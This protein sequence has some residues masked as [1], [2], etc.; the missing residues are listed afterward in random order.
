MSYSGMTK[1]FLGLLD[2]YK[3]DK[4][5]K[6][7]KEIGDTVDKHI[8][9]VDGQY[10]FN[11]Q[12]II[13]QN[14]FLL[15]LDKWE[16]F[17]TEKDFTDKKLKD[18][19]NK[20]IK[21]FLGTGES[22][23][24]VIKRL[25]SL[26]VS[27]GIESFSQ[28]EITFKFIKKWIK[29]S[30]E[31]EVKYRPDIWLDW[32][33]INAKNIS[34]STHVAKL[35]HSSIKGATNIYF[36]KI[37]KKALFF[38]TSSLFEKATD[39]SQTD[40]KLSPIGKFL[41]LKHNNMRM[42]DKLKKE[43]MS[44][45]KSFSISDKQLTLWKENFY[46]AFKSTRSS[47]HFLAK[48]MYF[49]IDK[50]YHMISPLVSS[51]L[52]QVIYDKIQYSKYK[53]SKKNREQKKNDKYHKDINIWYSNLAV[54]KVTGSNHTNASPL[55]GK[56]GGI[57]YLFPSTP[58]EWK[59]L[60]TP[61]LN[62]TSL[63][64]REYESRVWKQIKELQEYLLKIK[65]NKPNMYIKDNVRRNINLIIDTLFNYVAEIQNLNEL[66]GWSQEEG[67]LKESHRLWLDP[68]CEDELFQ[69]KRAKNEWQDEVCRDFGLWLNKKLEHKE[70]LFVKINSDRWAKI[71]KGRLK[72]FEWDLE[73][74]R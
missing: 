47:S 56:R 28:S 43:D 20:K 34:F 64:R 18:R 30:K 24:D 46:D 54:L 63:F 17:K 49:P 66:R 51:S 71:L 19:I 73:V 31:I 9:V 3:I 55:N 16:K 15:E 52:E 37:D 25:K 61:P 29:K 42:I 11:K 10:F 13:W 74:S 48:Q 59:S 33:S 65:D 7:V 1:E 69:T 60:L 27:M 6:L 68:Y 23:I 57:R 72:E 50:G 8:E 38:S 21:E 58:P 41:Q 36:D 67:R 32:A 5:K 22:E 44:D 4:I 14:E 12:E 39:V 70:M 62:Y 2:S 26:K 40:S 53:E 45:L 35:T